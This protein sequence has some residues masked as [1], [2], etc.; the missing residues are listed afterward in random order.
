[1][2]HTGTTIDTDTLN[3]SDLRL[4]DEMYYFDYSA[5]KF[6]TRIDDIS[7]YYKVGKS[8]G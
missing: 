5:F 2:C 8:L 3:V 6:L 7:D 1:M 4:P